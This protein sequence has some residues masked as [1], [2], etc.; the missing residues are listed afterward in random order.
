MNEKEVEDKLKGFQT[1]IEKLTK[2][3]E[4]SKKK[5]DSG[6]QL[7]DRY[8]QEMGDARKEIQE[9]VQAVTKMKDDTMSLS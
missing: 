9:Q 3:L 1:D 8:K 7:L 4:D 2:E 6:Q 5:V